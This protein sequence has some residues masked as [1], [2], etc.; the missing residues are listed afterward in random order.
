MLDAV[1]VLLIPVIAFLGMALGLLYTGID[2]KLAARMQARIG[3]P[4]IQ[5]FRDIRKLLVK[6]TIVPDDAVGWLFNSMPVLGLATAITVL[7]YLPLGC[8][9]PIFKG[10]G[11]L[12]LILYLLILPSL[13]IVIGGF[14]S[15]SPYATV[16]AQREMVTM[17]SYELPLTISVISV[18]WLVSL[19]NPG[20]PAFSLDVVS[21]N[22][23]WYMVGPLGFIGL[24]ILLMVLL[25]VIPGELGKTPFDVAE[26]ETEIAGGVF[27]EYS[28][29][30]LALFY[31]TGAVRT[32]AV[33][34]LV[35][36]MFLPWNASG[37][38]GLSGLLGMVADVM[39]FLFKLFVVVFL[40]SAF[41]RVIVARLRINQ[42]VRFYW[43]Y[44][45]AAAFLG[46]VLIWIDAVLL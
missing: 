25:W 6:E 24:G 36:S 34:S 44:A 4:L 15:G 21:A 38:L 46:M 27:V 2:R 22:P 23:V 1:R 28:G 29:R 40:G 8:P 30:N 20:A 16:G 9:E 11:D 7:L 19:T 18:A 10:Y 42:V 31:L 45:T 41:I 39:F 43:F 33:A 14:A 13:A 17:I 3:P 12:V 26:A 5:P 37:I 32:I 35:I